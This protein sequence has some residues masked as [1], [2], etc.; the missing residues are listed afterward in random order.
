MQPSGYVPVM[1]GA[2]RRRAPRLHGFCCTVAGLAPGFYEPAMSR[3]AAPPLPIGK[4]GRVRHLRSH[5]LTPND[6]PAIRQLRRKGVSYR[7]GAAASA[8]TSLAILPSAP[9]A[10]EQRSVLRTRNPAAGE[11]VTGCPAIRLPLGSR[12]PPSN[13]CARRDDLI[14]PG[15]LARAACMQIDRYSL[16]REP[17]TVEESEHAPHKPRRRS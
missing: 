13:R 11:L 15:Y 9:S 17:R 5:R 14:V 4:R 8:T 3:G 16:R 1:F 2:G 12:Y 10:P 7:V 6:V